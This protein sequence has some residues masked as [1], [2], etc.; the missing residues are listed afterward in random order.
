MPPYD[1]G[2]LCLEPERVTAGGKPMAIRRRLEQYPLP[3]RA[4]RA[5]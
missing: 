2:D 4:G 5:D 3:S 1:Q